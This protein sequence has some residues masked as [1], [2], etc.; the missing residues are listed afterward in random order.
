MQSQEVAKSGRGVRRRA[1]ALAKVMTFIIF[2]QRLAHIDQPDAYRDEP[3]KENP[4]KKIGPLKSVSD[5]SA[6]GTDIESDGDSDA[7][8]SVLDDMTF[9]P[10]QARGKLPPPTNG[11]S[12]SHSVND[13]SSLRDHSDIQY[14]GLC[15]KNHRDGP[16]ECPMTERS[17]NLATFRK[18]LL[19][20]ADDEPWEQRVNE[21]E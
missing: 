1:A 11:A 7:T 13:I 9:E 2:R 12:E 17:E 20:N 8:N 14:C 19:L 6:Y 10:P 15:A 4:K 18:M 16:G 3:S 21:L 5:G